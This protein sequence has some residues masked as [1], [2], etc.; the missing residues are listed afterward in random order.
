MTQPKY[1]CC[2]CGDRIET[3]GADP[4]GLALMAGF[5]LP[6]DDQMSQGFFCHMRCFEERLHR[7]TPLYT[8]D[9]LDN[10]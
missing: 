7:S 9:L 6:S 10:S 3:K 4:C 8:K 1:Q 5:V 2:F